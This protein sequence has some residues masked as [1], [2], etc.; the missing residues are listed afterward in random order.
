MRPCAQ[1]GLIR[2]D[3][4]EMTGPQFDAALSEF[5]GIYAAMQELHIPFDVIA[6][7]HLEA[8]VGN[9]GLQ[10]YRAVILSNAGELSKSNVQA[11]DEWVFAGGCLLANASTSITAK[12]T[13]QLQALPINRQLAVDNERADL[14][15]SH[16]AEP[17]AKSSEHIYT[18]P[19][20]PL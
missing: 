14:W 7:E 16:Y 1:T 8:T 15:S 12:G 18:G 19:M 10:R 3:R 9:G 20:V 2:P 11:L 17:Q 5:R 13:V 6:Q 4:A